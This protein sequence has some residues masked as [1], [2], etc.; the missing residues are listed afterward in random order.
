MIHGIQKAFLMLG[1]WTV[2]ST[3][4]FRELKS[5]DGSN[6]SRHHSEELE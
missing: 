2:L 6:V 4:I 3:I 1:L 5:G